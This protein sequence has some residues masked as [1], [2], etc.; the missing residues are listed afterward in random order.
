M[1]KIALGCGHPL[2]QP[3]C[4]SGSE[5]FDVSGSRLFIPM[6]LGNHYYTNERLRRLYHDFAKASDSSLVFLCDHLRYLSYLIRG[7]SNEE[8]IRNRVATQVVQM[9]VTLAHCGFVPS[10][11]LSIQCWGD[12]ASD[13][14][15]AEITQKLEDLIRKDA[16]VAK[17]AS[18]SCEFFLRKFRGN[19]PTQ[20]RA[21]E[22]QKQYLVAETALSIYM[23]EC[24]GFDYEVYRRGAGFVDF[25]YESKT[26]EIRSL[27]GGSANRKL[28]SLES[29]WQEL[30]S[31][32]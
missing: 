1:T 4:T 8:D 25:L 14:R 10:E 23:N 9:K 29:I 27:S 15:V 21:S 2:R 6:S 32:P 5:G 17:E 26:E 18:T 16:D 12:I 3:G 7:E 24:V 20:K 13:V 11:K 28:L 22:I 19:S 31:T 30:P